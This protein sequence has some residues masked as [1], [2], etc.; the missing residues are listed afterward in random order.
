M[1]WRRH[2]R[3]PDR[4]LRAIGAEDPTYTGDVETPHLTFDRIERR[5][6]VGYGNAVFSTCVQDLL[7]WK[8][9][10]RAGMQVHASSERAEV[11]VDVVLGERIGPLTIWAPCRVV[12]VL[13]TEHRNGFSY[14]TLPGHPE[15]GIEEFVIELLRDKS[16]W[17]TL[18]ATS[19]AGSTI[20]R[21]AGPAGKYFQRAITNRYIAAIRISAN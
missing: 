17:F 12:R 3:M 19:R 18:R 10:R 2:S 8:V 13:R 16:V 1:T 20:T 21:L 5:A 11:G 7:G 14:A 9:H 15:C 4:I 6:L